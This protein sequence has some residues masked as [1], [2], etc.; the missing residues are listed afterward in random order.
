MKV[1]KKTRRTKRTTGRRG[2]RMKTWRKKGGGERRG[3]K[4]G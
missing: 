2:R 1:K 3:R 4:R